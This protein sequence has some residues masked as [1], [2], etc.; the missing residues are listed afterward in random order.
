MRKK[1]REGNKTKKSQQLCIAYFLGRYWHL[2]RLDSPLRVSK[3]RIEAFA[4]CSQYSFQH[5]NSRWLPCS[6]REY[7]SAAKLWQPTVSSPRVYFCFTARSA[8]LAWQPVPR[9]SEY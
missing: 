7:S 2:F 8:C 6:G 9:E 3:K 5:S 4:T 1:S